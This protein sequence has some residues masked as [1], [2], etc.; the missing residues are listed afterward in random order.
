MTFAEFC[1]PFLRD[2]QVVIITP[3][4][5][6]GALQFYNI[7]KQKGC[8]KGVIFA[9]AECM[10]YAC[11]KKAPTTKWKIEYKKGYCIAT[12]PSKYN[13]KVMELFQKVYPEVLPVVIIIETGLSNCDPIIITL[14]MVLNAGYTDIT[15]GDFL[16]VEYFGNGKRRMKFSW[17]YSINRIDRKLETY[18][19]Q[20]P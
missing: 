5:F 10:I 4:N 8:A 13:D 17:A 6:G 18:Q 15:K 16:S 9:E 7:F 1:T 11:R 20:K 14:V 19:N 2:N 12:L 3:G